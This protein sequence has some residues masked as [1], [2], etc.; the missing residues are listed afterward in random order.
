[1]ELKP[2]LTNLKKV[3]RPPREAE[4]YTWYVVR[5]ISI[6]FTWVLVRT[7]I[8]AN[9]VTVLQEIFGVLGA[10]FLGLGSVAYAIVG[11]ILLQLGCILDHSDGEIARWKGQE[12]INGVFL[13]LVGHIIVI[14]LYMFAL[15]FGVW[16]RTGSVETL[17]SGF[18]SAMFVIKIERNTLL[19]V[20]DT[21]VTNVGTPK[22]TFDHL[23]GKLANASEQVEMGS[24]GNVGIRSPVQALF[25]YPMSMNVVMLAVILD[26][27]YEGLHIGPR[28]YPFTYFVTISFGLV[29]TLGRLWQ[30]RR[31]F[32]GNLTELRFLQIVKLARKI[33]RDK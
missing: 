13:D 32:K 27:L 4:P 22:Y 15:G 14:P 24:A 2:T 28:F 3:A 20:V 7:P 17:V 9:Q 21:L 33:Y 11:V 12:S 19:D 26:A 6:Y 16:M 29:L 30:I 5:P 23:R 18:L 10:I 25:R 8:T 31:V 1:M